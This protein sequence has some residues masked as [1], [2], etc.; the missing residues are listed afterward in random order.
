MKFLI[1]DDNKEDIDHLISL[2]DSFSEK[3]AIIFDIDICDIGM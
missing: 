1:Y 3:C 2:L